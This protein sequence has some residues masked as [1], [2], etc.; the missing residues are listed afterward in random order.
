MEVIFI[1]KL[2]ER[3]V[4]DTDENPLNQNIREKINEF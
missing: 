4:D 1:T 3:D 2:C